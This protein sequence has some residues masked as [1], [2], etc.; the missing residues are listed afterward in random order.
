MS[1]KKNELDLPRS[2]ARSPGRNGLR[3]CHVE[4]PIRRRKGGLGIGNCR[5]AGTAPGTT[6]RPRPADRI[7][8]SRRLPLLSKTSR[9]TFSRQEIART[10]GRHHRLSAPTLPASKNAQR[11]TH[12][13][14]SPAAWKTWTG[15]AAT[16]P[17]PSRRLTKKPSLPTAPVSP[18]RNSPRQA[19]ASSKTK[20]STS[21]PNSPSPKNPCGK[22]LDK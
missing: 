2:F 16:S 14:P 1:K 17:R 11:R 20:S 3:N 13:G 15:L 19:S 8:R 22:R 10:S 7:A 21:P 5:R 9:R 6:P 18:P 4:N 12:G